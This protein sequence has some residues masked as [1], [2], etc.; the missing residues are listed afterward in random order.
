MPQWGQ[1]RS[2]WLTGLPQFVQ[3]VSSEL[4][5]RGSEPSRLRCIANPPN[6]ATRRDLTGLMA[7]DAIADSFA[8]IWPLQRS[9]DTRIAAP[10]LGVPSV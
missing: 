2:S 9:D 6:P 1:T 7:G 3:T 4:D 8:R 5:G 10:G